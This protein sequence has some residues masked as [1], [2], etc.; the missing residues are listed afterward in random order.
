[1]RLFALH[2]YGILLITVENSI[3]GVVTAHDQRNTKLRPIRCVCLCSL[4]LSRSKKR[5]SRSSISYITHTSLKFQA[6]DFSS[7]YYEGC[8]VW[9]ADIGERVAF[10]F[11][12]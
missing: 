6:S 12:N 10:S 8:D 5:Y 11:I 2:S 1:M 4:L 9:F 7:A 3:I